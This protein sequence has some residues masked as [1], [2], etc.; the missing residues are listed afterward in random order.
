MK[1]SSYSYFLPQKPLL[2]FPDEFFL[3]LKNDQ[4]TKMNR[5]IV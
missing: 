4:M 5:K 1:Y 3:V 2:L